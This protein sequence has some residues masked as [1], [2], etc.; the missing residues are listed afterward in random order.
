MRKT[1]K[2]FHEFIEQAKLDSNVLGFVLGG[3][4]GKG[5]ITKDSDYDVNL[6]VENGSIKK[7]ERNYRRYNTKGIDLVIYDLSTFEKYA[8]WGS[9]EDWDRYDFYLAKVLVDKTKG[10]IKKIV[11]EKDKIPKDKV[12][13]VVVN[14]LGGY[15]NNV[16][17][18]FKCYRDK[19]KLAARLEAV[20]S[21]YYFLAALF[22][23]GDRLRPYHK[24]LEWELKNYPIKKWPWGPRKTINLLSKVLEKGD[25]KTQQ[26]LLV[27]VEKT[28]R[29][30][31]YRQV[32]ED[33]KDE[34]RW[35][36]SF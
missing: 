29:K 10:K 19:N 9:P 15:L 28:F 4:R 26:K 32:F 35:M 1:D 31:G 14:S 6:V 16:F 3:S 17:R 34:L 36:K 13:S 8:A 12:S 18:S 22:A 5:L 20:E 21:I 11:I 27:V 33:W 24:Y 23:L 25:V 30:H 2:L 7:C